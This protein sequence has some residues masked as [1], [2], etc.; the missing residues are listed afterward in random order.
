MHGIAAIKLP[1][2]SMASPDAHTCSDTTLAIPTFDV[3]AMDP[4]NDHPSDPHGEP[5]FLNIAHIFQEVQLDS[6]P[7][8]PLG[9]NEGQ[10]IGKMKGTTLDPTIGTELGLSQGTKEGTSAGKSNGT[11]PGA[12][13][14]STNRMDTGAMLSHKKGTPMGNKEGASKLL[15]T[16]NQLWKSTHKRW[17]TWFHKWHHTGN[18]DRFPQWCQDRSNARSQQK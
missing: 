13:L 9:T 8:T 5:L 15:Q 17:K 16:K 18:V 4:S 10:P 7:G 11:A 6:L 14:G 2:S 1:Q 3:T 12:I